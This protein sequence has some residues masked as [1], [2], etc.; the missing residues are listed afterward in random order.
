MVTSSLPPS[1]ISRTLSGVFSA[2]APAPAAAVNQVPPST[3][4]LSSVPL[5]P[6]PPVSFDTNKQ[7]PAPQQEV[8]TLPVALQ[9]SCVV[10]KSAVF[11]LRTVAN[12]RQRPESNNSSGS[13][14]IF[15]AMVVNEIGLGDRARGRTRSVCV[16]ADT[17][18]A[19]YALKKLA[20][21]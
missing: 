18:L 4:T 2:S 7:S 10:K 5:Q 3:S 8:N 20:T 12:I 6:N 1:L 15:T 14:A 16:C 13:L 11:C 9:G 17:E 19:N 21:G